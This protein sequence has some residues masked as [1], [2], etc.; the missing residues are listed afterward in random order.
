MR[1]VRSSSAWVAALVLAP[2]LTWAAASTPL[3][4]SK[5]DC[6]A[7]HTSPGA[8]T[9][10]KPLSGLCLDCHPGREAPAEHIVDVVPSMPVKQLPLRDGRM[11]CV[12]CH[13]PHT[14]KNGNLLRV[15]AR[16][17]CKHCHPY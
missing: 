7:C 3:P 12:T 2:V 9:L 1:A 17:L 4:D 11:T 14:N 10:R 8:A 16:A 13:D 5:K 6:T 15:P